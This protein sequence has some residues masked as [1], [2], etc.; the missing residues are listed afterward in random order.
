MKVDSAISG[1]G[2]LKKFHYNFDKEEFTDIINNIQKNKCKKSMEELIK[3]N[4]GLVNDVVFDMLSSV[5]SCEKSKTKMNSEDLVQEGIMGLMSAAEKFELERGLKFSTYATFWIKQKITRYVQN[6]MDTI[7][8]PVYLLQIKSTY[9]KKNKDKEATAK[10]YKISVEKLDEHLNKV[11]SVKIKKMQDKTGEDGK[12][13]LEEFLISYE[14]DPEEDYIKKINSKEFWNKIR[15]KLT[16]KEYTVIFERFHNEKKLEEIGNKL[17][18]TRERVRQ[19]EETALKKL[20][21]ELK[22]ESFD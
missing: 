6:N 9:L 21:L 10:S 1:A 22:R 17:K 7:R 2:N 13:E 12:S 18:V 5:N 19:I 16:E 20:A 14:E 4:M 11:E 3:R 15:K 8:I